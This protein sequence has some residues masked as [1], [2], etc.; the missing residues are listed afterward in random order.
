M[1]SIEADDLQLGQND[2]NDLQVRDFKFH[3][4]VIYQFIVMICTYIMF[5]AN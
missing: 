4:S 2:E 1:G 5:N 3:Y